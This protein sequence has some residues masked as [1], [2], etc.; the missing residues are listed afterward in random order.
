M[1]DVNTGRQESAGD[2]DGGGPSR[3]TVLLGGGLVA[4]LLAAV[5]ATGGWL[6]AGDDDDPEQPLAVA[7]ASATPTTQTTAPRPSTGRTTPSA[8]R[9]TATTT[10]AS[11]LTVPPVLG[12]DF[13]EARD[14][15]RKQRLGWRLVFGGGTGRTV[16]SASPAVGTEVV[17]GTTVQLQIAGPPPPAE[18]PDVVGD[19]CAK[20]ADELVEEGLYPS[21]RSGRSGKVT[22]Q[23]PAEDGPARWND[24]VSIWCGADPNGQPTA[25]PTL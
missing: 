17:R 9:T 14:M 25:K 6:L 8:P 22:R 12:A 11:G 13:E 23:E 24:Q 21:Y 10:K 1:T 2:R 20:A 5:G 19:D 3:A 7:T 16:E 15:L 18:V 4:V